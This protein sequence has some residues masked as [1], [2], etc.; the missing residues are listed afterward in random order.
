MNSV[1]ASVSFLE[2][3]IPGTI[4]LNNGRTLV[5]L[6][7]QKLALVSVLTLILLAGAGSAIVAMHVFDQNVE[8]K[9]LP[10]NLATP[11]SNQ[12]AS[13]TLDDM[14]TSTTTTSN[15]TLPA[16]TV[17]SNSTSTSN[18]GAADGSL[19]LGSPPQS[20]GHEV[21][22]D[23]SDDGSSSL[24]GNGTIIRTHFDD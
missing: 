10:I 16:S 6:M 14:N 2:F 20:N 12:T 8:G 19:L 11:Q 23:D 4:R 18:G 24:G 7:L 15:S 3:Q 1:L 5:D 22:E 13:S 17:S 9:V 21:G